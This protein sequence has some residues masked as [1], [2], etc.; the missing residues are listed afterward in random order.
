MIVVTGATGNVGEALVRT[1]TAQDEKVVAISRGEK[2]IR[3]QAGVEHRRADLAD[4]D[5]LAAAATGGDALFLL[6]SGEQGVAGPPPADV[7]SAIERAGVR[8]VVLLGSQSADTRPGNAAAPRLTA[9]EAALRNSELSWTI[10]R[11]G[12][13][14][15]NTF[16]WADSVRAQRTVHWPFGDVA[17]PQ[18]DPADIAEV[19]A[20]ALRSDQH[21]GRA[22]TLTGPEALSP[23]EQ[24][25]ILSQA[26]GEPITFHELTRDQAF[27]AMTEYMPEPVAAVT[28]S[29]LGTPTPAERQ[30]TPDVA[31]VLGR[32]ATP[33]ATWAA[34]HAD[35]FR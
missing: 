27:S 15:S 5:A 1:L 19:A 13:F 12:G 17:L 2:E 8:K 34:R 35:A 24:I 7:L 11:P 4:P 29:I 6:L 32:A 26:I 28:L 33:F 23:R 30:V 21:A 3:A 9:F 10:L 31:N 16:A 20:A 22:Y 25:R 18:I 14:F